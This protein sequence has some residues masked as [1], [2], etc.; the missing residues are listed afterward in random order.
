[1]LVITAPGATALTRMPLGPYMNALDFVRPT[2][3]CFDAVYAAP[4]DEP[5]RDAS[6]EVFTIEP[7]P[8]ASIAGMTARMSFIVP[9]TFTRNTRSQT[10]S[11][12]SPT[13]VMSSM[14][15]AMLARRRSGRRPPR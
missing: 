1:M 11:V 13:G 10:A 12:T 8:C 14:I 9:V 3:A 4:A 5:R 6:D 15:P 7:L 2:T